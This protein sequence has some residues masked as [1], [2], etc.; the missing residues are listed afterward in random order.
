MRIQEIMSKRVRL[1]SPDQTVREAA[2]KMAADDLGFLPVGNDE[3]LVGIITD[4]DIAVRVVALGRD[5]QA[6]IG[7]VMTDDVKY[8]YDD[9]EVDEVIANMGEIQV[10]RLPVVSRDKRLVGIVSL[11]DAARKHD[12]GA[13]GDSL[14]NVTEPGGRHSQGHNG[15]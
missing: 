10:R 15:R 3:R 9:Q 11:A 4:R 13:T 2:Q 6:R 5:G 7:D 12:P 1:M 8:C 14:G